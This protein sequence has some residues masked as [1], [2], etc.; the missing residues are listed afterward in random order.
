MA[1]ERVATPGL[2]RISLRPTAAKLASDA[3]ASITGAILRSRAAGRRSKWSRRESMKSD[4]AQIS[5]QVRAKIGGQ[6]V[7][8][9]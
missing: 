1:R 5:E 8:A 7:N 4:S 9:K 3:A 2:I 6:R